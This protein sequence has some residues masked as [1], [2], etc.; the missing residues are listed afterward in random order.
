MAYFKTGA[1]KK[2][3]KLYHGANSAAEVDEDQTLSSCDEVFVVDHALS[4][5][6]KENGTDS[7][8]MGH[9]HGDE[10]LFCDSNVSV[11]TCKCSRSLEKFNSGNGNFPS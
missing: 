1:R 5:T 10:A 9:M 8:A 2:T 7:G 4:V 11:A 6:S 3:H